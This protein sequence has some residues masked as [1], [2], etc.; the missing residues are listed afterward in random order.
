MMRH[1]IGFS[2]AM[3]TILGCGSPAPPLSAPTTTAAAEHEGAPRAPAGAA[4]APTAEGPPTAPS[5]C[6]LTV[7]NTE[8]CGP[9]DVE[10]LLAPARTRLENCRRASGGKLLVR[11]RKAAGRLAFDLE[12]GSSLDPTE[13]Q[14]VLEALSTI[15]DDES[16]TA[17][18]GLNI[19]PTG[20]TSLIT[21][22]W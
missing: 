5:R 7:T 2:L 12:P 18:T 3:C 4:S 10:E 20:F 9:H 11:V 21:I 14:C 16:S 1:P 22:E 17:W 13:K 6:R 8:G 15:H 19:R